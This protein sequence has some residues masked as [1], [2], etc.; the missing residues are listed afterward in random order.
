MNITNISITHLLYRGE[1]MKTLTKLLL[2]LTLLVSSALTK[3][4]DLCSYYSVGMF[5]YHW[6]READYNESNKMLGCDNIN[7]S[8]YSVH[9]FENSYGW[10]TVMLNYSY[11]VYNKNKYSIDFLAGINYGYKNKHLNV[12]DTGLSAQVLPR[13]SYN[14]DNLGLDVVILW[15][16][17]FV[18][19]SKFKF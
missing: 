8:D 4:E 6:D 11:V 3:A 17:G 10:D 1:T 9:Y 5:V 19:G 18:L 14:G 12:L 16:Q 2:G 7:G 13:L 15:D